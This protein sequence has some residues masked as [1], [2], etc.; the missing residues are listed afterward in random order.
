[1]DKDSFVLE[2]WRFLDQLLGPPIRVDKN[3]FVPSLFNNLLHIS[4][5]SKSKKSQIFFFKW[6]G[7]NGKNLKYFYSGAL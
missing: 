2:N 5:H 1:M 3:I 7:I 4:D 6:T